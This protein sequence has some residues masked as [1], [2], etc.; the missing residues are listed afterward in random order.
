M[1][2]TVTVTFQLTSADVFRA[3][4]ATIVRRYW[5]L[6]SLPVVGSLAVILAIVDPT[7]RGNLPG[8]GVAFLMALLIFAGLPYFQTRAVMKSPALRGPMR[9]TSSRVGIE[10]T[11]EH[12]QGSYDWAVV[13]RVIETRHAILIHLNPAG[14]QIV[15]KAQ[16]TE[17]DVASFRNV[18]RA[19]V[20]GKVKVRGA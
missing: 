18:V 2:D 9:L 17:A 11:T 8:A 16:L 15:P 5:L 4:A 13:K 10:Y 6:L 19:N 7:T 20:K 1:S 12:A 3:L 14:L